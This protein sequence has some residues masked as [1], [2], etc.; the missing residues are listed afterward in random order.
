MGEMSGAPKVLSYTALTIV[1]GFGLFLTALFAAF[2]LS[3]LS[4]GEAAAS[5]AAW[6]LPTLALVVLARWRPD[7]AGPVLVALTVVVGGFAVVD[8]AVGLLGTDLMFMVVL[9]V[10]IALA[11]LGLRRPSLAGLLLVLLAVAQTA[12][13]SLEVDALNLD[14]AVV[15]LFLAPGVLDLLAGVLGHDSLRFRHVPPTAHPAH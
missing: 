15:I 14:P 13:L 7:V 3:D 5:A 10:T 1:V 11:A 9:G 12:S 6:L 4:T 2:T 8:S